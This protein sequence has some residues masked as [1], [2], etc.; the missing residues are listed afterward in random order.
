MRSHYRACTLLSLIITVSILRT[1]LSL[2]LRKQIAVCAMHWE[3][4][5]RF[6]HV[7]AAVAWFSDALARTIACDGLSAWN[8]AFLN[9]LCKRARSA[10]SSIK[11]RCQEA[12]YIQSWCMPC[13]RSLS[14]L[15]SRDNSNIKIWNTSPSVIDC[16]LPSAAAKM[17]KRQIVDVHPFK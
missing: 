11:L 1:L 5:E 13:I 3:R 14:S 12:Y 9:K 6:P 7:L 2:S 17:I 10:A 16:E 15:C 8:S 4:R